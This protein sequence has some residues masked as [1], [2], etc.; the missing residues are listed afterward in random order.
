MRRQIDQIVAVGAIA[1]EQHNQLLRRPARSWRCNR[2]VEIEE[3]VHGA[4]LLP[5]NG[6]GLIVVAQSGAINQRRQ[7]E[8]GFEIF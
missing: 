3:I 7:D 2:A 5:G 4:G 8:R 1:M 6:D